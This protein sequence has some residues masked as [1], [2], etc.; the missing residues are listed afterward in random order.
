MVTKN[1]FKKFRSESGFT[2]L[3]LLIVIIVMG[4]LSTIVLMAVGNANRTANLTAC[5][6]DVQA[7]ASALQGWKNDHR[8]YLIPGTAT[9]VTLSDLVGEGYLSSQILNDP[10]KTYSLSIT[11]NNPGAQVRIARVGGSGSGVFNIESSSASAD[12]ECRKALGM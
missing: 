11:F 4:I 12:V 3:E 9:N 6:A 8:G 2:L 10:K 5:K 7:Y 1:L